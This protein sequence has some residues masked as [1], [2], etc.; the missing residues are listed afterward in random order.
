MCSNLLAQTVQKEGLIFA[1]IHGH[2]HSKILMS[3]RMLKLTPSTPQV[4]TP[5]CHRE[6]E[7]VCPCQQI[8]RSPCRLICDKIL[9]QHQLM[10][11]SISHL[12]LQPEWRPKWQLTQEVIY[13][14]DVL[15]MFNNTISIIS[16]KKKNLFRHKHLIVTDLF[17]KQGVRTLFLQFPCQ[18]WEKAQFQQQFGKTTPGKEVDLLLTPIL[19]EDLLLSAPT[20]SS[21]SNYQE[22]FSQLQCLLCQSFIFV[23]RKC[24]RSE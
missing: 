2:L 7:A 16:F 19:Y 11:S 18:S 21:S 12:M 8:K 4:T 6:Q 23:G 22:K 10:L 14:D 15:R 24:T 9:H 1:V 20:P 13:S 5:D 17:S 3:V